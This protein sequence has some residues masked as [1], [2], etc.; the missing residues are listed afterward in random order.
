MPKV[1]LEIKATRTITYE[2]SVEVEADVPQLM[3]DNPDGDNLHDWV[4]GQLKD[5]ESA[6]LAA[7]N[8]VG[9][10]KVEVDDEWELEE[11]VSE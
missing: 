8:A 1:R 11:V 4:E 3:L 7:S 6:L 2:E 5:P 9:W 10:V